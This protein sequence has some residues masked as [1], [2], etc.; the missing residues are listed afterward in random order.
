MPAHHPAISLA[1][2]ACQRSLRLAPLALAPLL[3]LASCHSP[4]PAPSPQAACPPRAEVLEAAARVFEQSYIRPEGASLAATSLRRAATDDRYARFCA[5][6][7]AFARALTNDLRRTT[8]DGHIMFEYAPGASSSGD[9][10]GWIDAWMKRGPSVGW[11]LAEAKVLA[12]GVGYIKLTSF[13]PPT[14]ASEP[15]GRALHEI[16]GADALVL[17]LRDNGG[18]DDDTA[19]ALMAA[20]LD[21]EGRVLLSYRDRQRVTREVKAAHVL[22]GPR[23]DTRKPLAV[24]LDRRSFSAAEAVAYVL[25]AEGRARIF[26]EP[27]A[28]GAHITTQERDLPRGFRLGVPD[29]APIQPR[30]GTNWEGK[31][32]TPDVATTREGALD[33]AL[34]WARSGEPAAP[35]LQGPESTNAAR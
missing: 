28:G 20:L 15:L 33:A 29:L 22:P 32:V 19:N 18:G 16:A 17:D 12:G 21:D 31:G 5:D 30:T 26:G 10:A 24:L 8:G 25:R 4:S 1:P 27:T 3:A 14:F 34:R 13:Y 2:A 35:R 11:G 7:R 6:D 23:F 9:D